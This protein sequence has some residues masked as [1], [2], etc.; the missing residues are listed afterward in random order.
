MMYPRDRKYTKEH[1]WVLLEADGDAV[2][3]I[4]SYAQEQLGDIVFVDLPSP[5]TRLAQFQ[6][7]GEVE[8]VKA[9]SDLYSP[10]AGEVL[11]ANARLVQHPELLN[12]DP[13][14]AAW[15][16]RLGGVDKADLE[17]LLSAKAYDQLLARQA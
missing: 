12:Q 15:L 4:T 7:L 9:V 3:G 14:G 8:S 2:V 1:E 13:H 16:V 17:N 5:G 6:K 10:V 11:E